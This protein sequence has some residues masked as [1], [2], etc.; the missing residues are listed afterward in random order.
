MY[1]YSQNDECCIRKNTLKVSFL[2]DIEKP[3]TL[4]HKHMQHLIYSTCTSI[5]CTVY[6]LHWFNWAP[7]YSL[8][9]KLNKIPVPK[10]SIFLE[11]W[12]IHNIAYFSFITHQPLLTW[13]EMFHWVSRYTL[14]PCNLCQRASVGEVGVGLCLLLHMKLQRS[15]KT[16]CNYWSGKRKL[17]LRYRGYSVY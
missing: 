7:T 2:I 14:P 12:D 17:L 5:E 16:R 4:F 1:M 6:V 13:F 8:L 9:C 3:E 11:P 10:F 15:L